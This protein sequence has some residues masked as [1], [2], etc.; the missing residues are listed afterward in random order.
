MKMNFI[1]RIQ[2]NLK[3]NRIIHTKRLSSGLLDG[4]Y[5]SIYKGRS[6]NFDELREYVTGDEIKDID[7][8][9]SAR[10]QKLLVRQY[11]AEKKHNIMLIIDTNRR[12]LADTNKNES[13][14]DVALISAGT[15][16]YMV[17]GNGDYVSATFLQGSLIRHFPFKTGLFNIENILANYNKEASVS[18]D[19]DLNKSFEYIINHYRRHMIIFIITDLKGMQII[20]ETILKKLLIIHDV[21]LI[22]ISDADMSG[23]NVYDVESKKYLSEF[24]TQDKKLKE[25]A[26]QRRLDIYHECIDKFKKLGIAMVT[27]DSIKD[28]DGKILELLNK[29]KGEKK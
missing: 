25:I 21:L 27:V 28:I 19:S 29:H 17:N 12:M 7:W 23:K 1:S 2:S 13:K 3:G 6:M 9:A 15:L 4:S 5:R 18:N 24:F 16:A 14:K 26:D 11:T 22:N 20:S 8:K 10:S